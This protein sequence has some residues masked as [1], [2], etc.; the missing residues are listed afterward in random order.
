[1]GVMIQVDLVQYKVL[2]TT[3]EH[4]RILIRI[5]IQITD[6]NILKLV[7]FLKLNT[8]VMR[9]MDQINLFIFT[10]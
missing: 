3:F 10:L 4:E 6:Q 7:C 2:H 5:S 1:M 9:I 8:I